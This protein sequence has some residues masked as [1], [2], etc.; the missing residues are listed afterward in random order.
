MSLEADDLQQRE[1]F[2]NQVA[3]LQAL[4]ASEQQFASTF[5]HAAIGVSLVSPDG[6][7]LRVN[8]ALCAMLGYSREE[9]LRKGFDELT[10]P[11]DRF[12]VGQDRERIALGEAHAVQKEKRYVHASGRVVWAH[13]STSVIRD[14]NGQPLHYVSQVQDITAHK[15]AEA[16]VRRNENWFRSVFENAATGIA[17]S[18]ATGRFLEANAAYCAMVGYSE[19]E[20]RHIDFLSLTHPDDW[21]HNQAMQ[22]ELMAGKRGMYTLEKRYLARDG[23]VVWGR[24]SVSSVHD[25]QNGNTAILAVA[26]DIT[27]QKL[28]QEALQQNQTLLSIAGRIGRIGGWTMALGSMKITLSDEVCGIHGIAPGSS[29]SLEEKVGFYAPHSRP[30]IQQALRNCAQQGVPFDVELQI[31]SGSGKHVWVRA[32]AEPVR[33]EEGTITH[34]QGALQDISERKEATEQKR[35]LSER[36]FATLESITDAFFTLD[37]AWCFTYVNREAE[38]VLHRSRKDLLGKNIWD[39]FPAALGSAFELELKRAVHESIAVQFEA[40][41]PPLGCWFDVRSYPSDQGLTVYFRDVS[42]RRQAQDEILRLNAELEERVRQRTAELELA[43]RELEAF[44]HSVAHDLRAPL[45]TIDG[46]GHML[47]KAMPV[48]GSDRARHYLQRI[49]ASVRQ[50]GDMTDALLGLAQV[51]RANLQRQDVNLGAMARG[52]LDTWREREPERAITVSIDDPLHAWG[53]PA[54]LKLVMENL[55]GNAW[56]FSGRKPAADIAVGRTRLAC[57]EAAYFVRD[58]GAGFEMASAKNLFGTF[59]RLHS[60]SEFAGTGVGL[61]N[62]HRIISRHGGKVWAESVPGEGSTFYFTLGPVPG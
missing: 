30:T 37:T 33:N 19:E 6:R 38:A 61:A 42:Q 40:F 58:A 28:A 12:S 27:E 24:V 11:E 4:H 46:F 44:S 17:M 57:G 53:D 56:K 62:V 35:Q 41:Y 29:P 36:L 49:I 39:Q 23:R 34:I 20:L 31:I 45:S 47:A 15:Q 50:M 2:R 54:L 3:I 5:E 55:L 14:P 8:D 10:H 32:I 59:Q 1:A 16:A 9:L 18:T 22:Q 25:D 52:I 7:W 26:Q 21:P 48:E 51:T 60:P 13:L 43:N